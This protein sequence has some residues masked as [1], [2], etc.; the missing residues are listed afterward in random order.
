MRRPTEAANGGGASF[1]ID[2]PSS[3][4]AV[5]TGRCELLQQP[6][7]A[8]GT[9]DEGVEEREYFTRDASFNLP[10]QLTDQNGTYTRTTVA[11]GK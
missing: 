2:K 6:L 7:A 1:A 8:G 9:C 3:S 4:I 11:C 10:S 5:G